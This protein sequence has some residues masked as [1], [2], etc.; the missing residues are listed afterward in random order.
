MSQSPDIVIDCVLG[1]FFQV[2]INNHAGIFCV[3]FVQGLD[4]LSPSHTG[5]SYQLFDGGILGD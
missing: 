2:V 5:G 1:Q 3:L 4:D